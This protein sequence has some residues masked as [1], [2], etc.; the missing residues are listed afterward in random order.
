MTYFMLFKDNFV[1]ML[2]EHL[3]WQK[4]LNVGS[5]YSSKFGLIKLNF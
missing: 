5:A 2:L 3:Y 4:T 1:N